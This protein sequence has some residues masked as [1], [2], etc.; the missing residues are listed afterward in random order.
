METT[1]HML[2]SNIV[3]EILL[4]HLAKKYFLYGEIDDDQDIFLLP[5]KHPM[6]E[7]K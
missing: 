2:L 7:R 3:S 5:K 4:Q 6:L 1:M